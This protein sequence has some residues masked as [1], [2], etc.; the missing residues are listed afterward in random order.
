MPQNLGGGAERDEAE[1]MD[2]DQEQR[3]AHHQFRRH[4]RKQHDEVGD[5]GCGTAPARE[6]E[7]QQNAQWCSD[8]HIEPGKLQALEQRMLQSRIVP[9]EGRKPF[10]GS[11]AYSLA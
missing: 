6:A 3:D 4:Q 2:E 1:E 11:S 5:R 7:R 10:S 9:A 8:Q